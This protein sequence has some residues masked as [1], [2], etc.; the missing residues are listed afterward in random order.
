MHFTDKTD[1]VTGLKVSSKMVKSLWIKL[2]EQ[3]RLKHAFKHGN[4]CA[5]IKTNRE[6]IPIIVVVYIL[7]GLI[8]VRFKK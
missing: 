3:M 1:V 5:S 8:L 7:K 2:A 6:K 4:W